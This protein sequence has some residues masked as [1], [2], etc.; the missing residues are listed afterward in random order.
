[1]KRSVLT[2]TFKQV[3]NHFLRIGL[4]ASKQLVRKPFVVVRRQLGL[5]P[6][7]NYDNTAQ[8][9]DESESPLT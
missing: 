6:G 9:L 5:P 2:S 3:V 4:M 7:L 8:L 1:M